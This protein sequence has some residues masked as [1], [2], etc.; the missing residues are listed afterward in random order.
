M[1]QSADSVKQA[2]FEELQKILNPDD[3]IRRQA[4]GRLAQLKFTEGEYFLFTQ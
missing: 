2:I 4:E 3:E 1:A